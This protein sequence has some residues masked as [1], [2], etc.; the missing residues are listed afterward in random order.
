MSFQ[1]Y[2]QRA[3]HLVRERG[4]DVPCFKAST[5][6]IYESSSHSRGG[7]QRGILAD[8][9][10]DVTSQDPKSTGRRWNVVRKTYCRSTSDFYQELIVL[11]Y[12]R[13]SINLVQI[14]AA[15]MHKH[16]LYL[17]VM[18]MDLEAF[19][20]TQS[21]QDLGFVELAALACN[22]VHGLHQLHNRMI[23]HCDLKPENVLVCREKTTGFWVAKLCDFNL[24]EP[25]AP[26]NSS[27]CRAYRLPR[28]NSLHNGN[29]LHKAPEVM[30]YSE[31]RDEIRYASPQ[32]D[33][34][35]LAILLW[36]LFVGENYDPP[37]KH[38]RS[39]PAFM[40][41]VIVN[42]GRP[43]LRRFIKD[44]SRLDG[45]ARVFVRDIAQ[46]LAQTWSTRPKRRL[47]LTNLVK[48]FNILYLD[49]LSLVRIEK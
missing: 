19:F 39:K 28:T 46:L 32:T 43:S 22:I 30:P 47:K 3:L 13:G 45:V 18:D 6:Y 8:T 14:V 35:G 49:A 20:T 12:T 23:L 31:W 41:Y 21:Y 16:H 26:P 5:T 10:V 33:V 37:D 36:E 44:V 15:D 17:E 27:D 7:V 2:L 40:R 34:V 48:V 24:A 11:L 38:S 9:L 25:F 4:T 29:L 1:I 42:H